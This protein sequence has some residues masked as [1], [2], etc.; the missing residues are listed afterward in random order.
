ML[1]PTAPEH[2]RLAGL[3][4][5]LLLAAH[6]ENLALPLPCDPRA[7]RMAY[8]IQHKP[9]DDRELGALA[10]LA[11]A[12]LR[13]FP[14]E[15]GLTIE[16]WR[17]KAR[18][19]AAIDGLSSGASVTDSAL[20]CGYLSVAAFIAAFAGQFGDTPSRYIAPD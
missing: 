7:F 19:L 1:T 10:N 3:L 4:A 20:D 14:R 8:L 15:T 16:A 5:D 18:L 6:P 9:A 13:L 12:S 17:Q 11:G 2:D